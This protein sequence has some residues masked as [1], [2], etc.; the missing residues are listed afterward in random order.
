MPPEQ[1]QYTTEV[2]EFVE[3]RKEFGGVSTYVFRPRNPVVFVAGQY[4][5]VRLLNMSEDMRRVHEFS[6]A[7]APHED[8]IEFGIDERSGSDYQK[9]LQSLNPG[10]TIEL[11]K[12]KSHVTW[13]APVYDIVMIAGG[14]G[15][16][17]FRAML[18]DAKHQ[19]LA[20]TSAFVHVA[21]GT[22]LYGDEMKKLAGEYKAIGRPELAETLAEVAE[23]H[24][25]AHYYVAG[26]AGFIEAVVATLG[27]RG[28]T[29]I[30]SDLFKGLETE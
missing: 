14:V 22:H 24:P 3:R 30:E 23:V 20:H 7:S 29:R 19:G 2:L 9:A 18:R 13:P 10:D 27:E 28:I 17:P 6:F 11:F 25:D 1:P 8:L 26:S 15:V 12:I 21:S 16:T 4:V 5:H